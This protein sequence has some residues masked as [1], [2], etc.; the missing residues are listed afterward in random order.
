MVIYFVH[1]NYF[2]HLLISIS[3]GNLR[4][5]KKE[6]CQIDTPLFIE[7]LQ[8]VI[9]SLRSYRSESC[10]LLRQENGEGQG[11]SSP[12]LEVHRD[13]IHNLLGSHAA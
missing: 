13:S 1:K 5:A 12:S 8:R 4:Q 7:F 11:R 9:I 6:G 3:Q 2:A 10:C